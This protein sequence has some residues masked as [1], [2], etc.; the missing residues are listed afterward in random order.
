MNSLAQL[1]Q[2]TDFN[3]GSYMNDETAPVIVYSSYSREADYQTLLCLYNIT[4]E[5]HMRVKV[6]LMIID[7]N[8]LLPSIYPSVI[9]PGITI[10]SKGKVVDKFHEHVHLDELR[11]VIKTIVGNSHLL[12]A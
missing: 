12:V 3:F 9:N 2:M 4:E 7:E 11:M 1:D 6:C 8:F 5:F 10:F